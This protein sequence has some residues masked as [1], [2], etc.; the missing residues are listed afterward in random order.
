MDPADQEADP[1]GTASVLAYGTLHTTQQA[2]PEYRRCAL[3]MLGQTK[4]SEAEARL[5]YQAEQRRPWFQYH[6]TG[7][8]PSPPPRSRRSSP[9]ARG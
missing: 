7:G 1:L 5:A 2:L 4:E 6:P 9:G 8:T 3:A